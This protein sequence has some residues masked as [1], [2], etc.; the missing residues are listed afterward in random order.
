MWRENLKRAEVSSVGVNVLVFVQFI[1]FIKQSPERRLGER[2]RKALRKGQPGAP[3]W[4][5]R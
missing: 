1:G 3:G 5:S 2:E 4:R